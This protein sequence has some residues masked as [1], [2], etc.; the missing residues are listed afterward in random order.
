MS[1]HSGAA[2]HEPQH[3]YTC[4]SR[5]T[6][7]RAAFSASA[8]LSP[9]P[10]A[11]DHPHDP[12]I[13]YRRS[14]GNTPTQRTYNRRLSTETRTMSLTSEANSEDEQG[15]YKSDASETGSKSSRRRKR[16]S[17]TITT[18][19]FVIAQ[20]APLTVHQ[21]RLHIRPRLLFQLQRISPDRRPMP[22]I[23]VQASTRLN[24]RLVKDF[25]RMFKG[26]RALKPND[27]IILK[28]EDYNTH[29]D[30]KTL[31][32]ND[33]EEGRFREALAVI[34]ESGPNEAEI[35]L[36]D[37]TVWHAAMDGK[38]FEF[39]TTD[40]SGKTKTVRWISRSQTK[41]LSGS[42]WATPTSPTSGELI[43]KWLSRCT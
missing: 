36:I 9:R 1:L 26:N 22:V 41:R 8:K 23:D 16:C 27:V 17:T 19:S 33:D 3:P 30:T 29:K 43:V 21:K 39:T 14:T 42:G 4:T 32:R 11:F 7:S 38:R 34:C 15:Y 24:A 25:P 18:T 5:P 35:C 13:P 10:D 6:I 2:I 37:G 20:P 12:R 28:S 40:H 31:T